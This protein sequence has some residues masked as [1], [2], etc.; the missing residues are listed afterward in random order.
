MKKLYYS[1]NK[2]FQNTEFSVYY[3]GIINTYYDKDNDDWEEISSL[4][5]SDDILIL[6][7]D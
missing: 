3:D 2:Q 1:I 4:I 6:N 5:N 7:Y